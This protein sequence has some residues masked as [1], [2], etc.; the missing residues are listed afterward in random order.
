MAKY[1]R[2]IMNRELFVLPTEANAEAAR[3]AILSL[4]I[5][6]APVLDDL[7]RPRGVV[8]LRDLA[9]AKD[10]WPVTR[11]MSTPADV[12]GDTATI[13]DAGR[14]LAQRGRHRLVV[15]DDAGKA[16]GMISA[17]D[18]VRGLLGLPVRHPDAFPHI[19]PSTGVVWSDDFALDGQHLGAAPTGPG[20]I[21]L[22]Y[23][24]FGSTDVPVWIGETAAVRRRLEDMLTSPAHEDPVLHHWLRDQIDHLRFRACHIDDAARR[25]DVLERLAAS[26]RTLAWSQRWLDDGALDDG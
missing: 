23:G 9:S 17:I 4:D 10:T 16:V 8:S 12:I 7:G 18:I 13:D 5:T 25:A 24:R 19:E 15:V 14:A 11:C 20:L 2:E 6:A 21:V 22:S 26:S 1:V 3:E